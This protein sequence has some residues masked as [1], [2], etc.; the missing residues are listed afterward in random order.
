MR[1]PEQKQ[2]SPCDGSMENIPV[3]DHVLDIGI[4]D[5]GI[6]GQTNIISVTCYVYTSKAVK[7]Q[8]IE[9]AGFWSRTGGL[10]C[11]NRWLIDRV[12]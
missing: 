10:C 9:I 2:V 1:S 3:N 4:L 8:G 11:W 6:P 7:L 12:R 5:I